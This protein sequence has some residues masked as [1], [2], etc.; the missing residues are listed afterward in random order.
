M[1]IP[2]TETFEKEKSLDQQRR[3]FIECFPEKIGAPDEKLEY[4]EWKFHS[5][6]SERKSFEYCAVYEG[7]IIGYYAAVPHYYLINGKCLQKERT[8]SFTTKTPIA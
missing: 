7:E 1:V 3:L 8:T 4:Y 5:Y 2:F 6:P